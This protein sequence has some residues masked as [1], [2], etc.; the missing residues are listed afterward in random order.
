VPPRVERQ[1]GERR[2]RV[3]ARVVHEHVDVAE[4]LQHRRGEAG[5]VVGRAHV[6]ALREHVAAG[7]A[8]QLLG[9]ARVGH[10]GDG[11]PETVRGEAPRVGLPDPHRGPAYHG[12]PAVGGVLRPLRHGLLT[13]CRLLVGRAAGGG[14]RPDATGRG[15]PPRRPSGHACRSQFGRPA[16]C[17]TPGFSAH[18]YSS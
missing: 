6:A 13:R 2:E 8:D 16:L 12:H 9:L 17:Q 11:D 15:P 7:R 3:D 1:V 18:T 5:D 14:A 4:V 10:V